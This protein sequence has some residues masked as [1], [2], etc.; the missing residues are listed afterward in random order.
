M[1]NNRK[2]GK[3]TISN[4]KMIKCD[5]CDVVDY[6]PTTSNKVA[7]E[8]ANNNGWHYVNGIDVC[9]DCYAD[10]IQRIKNKAGIK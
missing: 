5:C 9:K 8:M 2:G 1:L 7:R 10:A 4:Y 3:M 6:Y